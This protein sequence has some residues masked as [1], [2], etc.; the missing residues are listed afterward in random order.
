M[1]EVS[2]KQ[3][4]LRLGIYDE[5]RVPRVSATQI[6]SESLMFEEPSKKNEEV[7]VFLPDV[8]LPGKLPLSY[9]S[10]FLFHTTIASMLT[11]RRKHT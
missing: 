2:L 6:W 11:L 9:Y 10:I 4:S 5:V 7:R 8:Q 1:A 3:I